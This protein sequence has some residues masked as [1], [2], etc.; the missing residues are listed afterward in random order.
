MTMLNPKPSRHCQ[1]VAGF[2]LGERVAAGPHATVYRGER[3]G[4]QAAVKIYD[5]EQAAAWGERVRREGEAQQQVKH[6]CVAQLLSSGVLPDGALYVVSAWV[7]GQRLEDRIAA[8]PMTWQE[9]HPIVQALGRGLH[10]I[11]SAGVVHRDLKPSNVILPASGD[12]HAVIL[13]FGHSLVLSEDRLTETGQILGTASYTAPEQA[14]GRTI[15]ARADLYALGVI[16]YRALTGVLPFVDPSPAEVLRRHLSE[17]VIPP[18]T[19]APQL[20]ILPAAEDLCMWLLAKDPDARVPNTRV[21]AIT[22][23][24]LAREAGLPS[25]RTPSEHVA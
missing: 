22:L 13:D 20:A 9:L 24:S 3:A 5:A 8:R 2:Q 15:D 11:H 16:L 17:P 19:R 25:A 4:A 12:P 14:A 23:Q 7:D 18:R 21:L 10:A 6:P 1:T